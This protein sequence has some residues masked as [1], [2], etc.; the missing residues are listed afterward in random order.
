MPAHP[1]PPSALSPFSF[2][3]FFSFLCFFFE[4]VVVAFVVPHLRHQNHA[5][6]RHFPHPPYRVFLPAPL[7]RLRVSHQIQL[8]RLGSLRLALLPL[9]DVLNFRGAGAHDLLL[10]QRQ[11]RI[12]PLLRDAVLTLSTR[13]G[14]PF[15]SL[16]S[17]GDDLKPATV[18]RPA[19]IGIAHTKRPRAGREVVNSFRVF[20]ILHAQRTRHEAVFNPGLR[21]IQAVLRLH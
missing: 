16:Y 15:E 6:R 9:Q 3:S 21:A 19:R 12:Q 5:P 7:R 20:N 13:G 18:V 10:Q 2:F 11:Q 17:G 1:A 4:V 8:L 14:L